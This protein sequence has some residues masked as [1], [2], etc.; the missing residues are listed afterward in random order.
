MSS[1][2]PPSGPIRPFT[3]LPLCVPPCRRVLSSRRSLRGAAGACPSALSRPLPGHIALAADT[4]V[5]NRHARDQGS[6][7]GRERPDRHPPDHGR[8]AHLR[9]PPPRRPGS[10][11][12]PRCVSLIHFLT[13]RSC[14]HA[15]PLPVLQSGSGTTS[16]IRRGCCCHRM[17]RFGCKSPNAADAAPFNISVAFVAGAMVC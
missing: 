7:S 14:A 13:P 8:R 16:K 17:Y 6:A 15:D 9:P 5:R 10:R 2:E 11:H 1:V 4:L 12:V 3:S